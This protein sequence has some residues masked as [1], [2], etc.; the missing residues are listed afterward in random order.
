MDVGSHFGD[1]CLDQTESFIHTRLVEVGPHGISVR[2]VG[3]NRAGEV[4]M[5]RFLRNEK[6]TVNKIVEKAASHTASRVD[7]IVA[8]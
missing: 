5:G 1:Y 3:G 6:V 7:G 2:S 8:P 4:R